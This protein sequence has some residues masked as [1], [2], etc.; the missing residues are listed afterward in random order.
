M[1]VCIS[2]QFLPQDSYI[3]S[4][5]HCH[6]AWCSNPVFKATYSIYKR[7]QAGPRKCLFT[8]SRVE[9]NCKLMV[10]RL[11]KGIS[12][13]LLILAALWQVLLASAICTKSGKALLSRQFVE[14]TKVGLIHLHLS[15]LNSCSLR[16]NYSF[17]S[18]ERRASRACWPPSPSWWAHRRRRGPSRRRSSTPSWRQSRCATSTS[19]WR[20]ST[21]CSSPPRPA[22]SSRTSRH[23][24]SSPEWWVCIWPAAE[25][26]HLFLRPLT[27]AD[28]I[29][30]ALLSENEQS[31]GLFM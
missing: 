7:G 16:N 8:A 3:H 24:G 9:L 11:F 15:A 22:T 30:G 25:N 13:A 27:P 10:F 6:C 26:A 1:V 21:C 19:P 14:M 31:L 23:S 12:N 17:H 29:C 5:C 2:H 18:F 4:S 28:E 20:S